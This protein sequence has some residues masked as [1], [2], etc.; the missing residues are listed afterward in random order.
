MF[1]GFV[2]LKTNDEKLNGVNKQDKLGCTE[3]HRTLIKNPT[4]DTILKVKSLLEEKKADPN[5]GDSWGDTALIYAA[6]HGNNEIS[7]LLIEHK[8]EVNKPN[9]WGRTALYFAAYN[10]HFNT[11]SLLIKQGANPCLA[12][13]NGETPLMAARENKAS[14]ELC[15]YLDAITDENSVTRLEGDLKNSRLVAIRR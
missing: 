11:V 1:R 6:R 14:E 7:Q 3:L 5:I 15:N 4:S 2:S 9:V 13:E 8:A 10:N 12:A